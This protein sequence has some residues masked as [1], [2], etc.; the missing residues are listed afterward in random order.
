M[1]QRTNIQ[2]IGLLVFLIFIASWVSIIAFGIQFISPKENHIPFGMNY[3]NTIPI[4]YPG[5]T[6]NINFNLTY[7]GDLAENTPIQVQNASCLAT[8][9]DSN[10]SFVIIGFAQAIAVVNGT[11]NRLVGGTYVAIFST[12]NTNENFLSVY[13]VNTF[14][15]PVSG[16]FSPTVIINFNNGT[17]QIQYRYDD[18]KLHVLATSEVNAERINT[19]NL[20]LTAALLGF[21]FIETFKLIFEIKSKDKKNQSIQKAIT[22]PTENNPSPNTN[23]EKNTSLQTKLDDQTIGKEVKENNIKTKPDIAKSKP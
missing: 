8:V 16:D 7:T 18:I 21:A 5:T 9:N 1:T 13:A 3:P 23:N 15:F 22:Q 2:V 10:I 17:G 6:F 4:T 12:P 20:V 14:Y 11:N 19:T